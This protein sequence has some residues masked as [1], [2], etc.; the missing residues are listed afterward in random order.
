[1]PLRA[2]EKE[3][4]QIGV[5]EIHAGLQ[6]VG[7]PDPGEVVAQLILAFERRLWDV[8]V[9]ADLHSR[10]YEVRLVGDAEDLVLEILEV[11]AELVQLRSAQSRGQIEDEAV[12]LVVTGVAARQ[13]GSRWHWDLIV[14][15]RD[16]MVGLAVED[17]V[18]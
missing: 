14:G 13:V 12:Q 9:L 5:D 6:V 16:L 7:A 15:R 11:K 3:A 18:V 17:R 10:E 8:G 1:M 2:E 4:A